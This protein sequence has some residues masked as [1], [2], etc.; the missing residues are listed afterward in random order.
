MTVTKVQWGDDSDGA[1]EARLRIA[2]PADLAG[3]IALENATFTS[4]RLSPRQWRRHIR[5]PNAS[6]IVSSTRAGVVAAAVLFFRKV[7]RSAR[8]YSIAV[9]S[10]ARGQG[11]GERLLDA[12][13]E[14]AR[15]R[16]CVSLRLEVRDDNEPAKRL[17][18]R[19]G[20]ALFDRRENYYEDGEVALRY[21]KSLR[22][23]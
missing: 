12:C 7:S 5:N 16:G 21:E 15:L 17:Y 19:H 13:E 18:E 4:D 10:A 9:S 14:A 11:L 2:T 20:F 22:G 23:N 8:L 6:I 3:L 1:N